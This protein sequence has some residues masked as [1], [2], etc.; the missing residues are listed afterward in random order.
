MGDVGARR[1]I[2]AALQALSDALR[3]AGRKARSR[4]FRLCFVDVTPILR[5]RRP[6]PRRV[7]SRTQ[8]EWRV[9]MLLGGRGSGKTRAG[10]E[11]VRAKACDPRFG[12][13]A[14][15]ALVGKTTRRRAQRHDRRRVGFAGDPS[16]SRATAVRDFE[17][18]ADVAERCDRADV[19]R[20]EADSCAV[21]SSRTPGAMNLR[22]GTARKPPGTCCSSRCGWAK[23]R[24]RS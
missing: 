9:W 4:R 23:R 13:E 12:H 5:P 2:A 1:A 22:S 6:A 7:R 20:D 16:G 10:A 3:R 15:I 21:R 8:S 24:R 17:A 14:R 11:W 19:W 18:A